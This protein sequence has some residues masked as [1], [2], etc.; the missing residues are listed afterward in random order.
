[1]PLTAMRDQSLSCF[2]DREPAEVGRAREETRKA[3]FGWGLGG[4]R[5]LAEI[6]ISEWSPMPS[7]M[8]KG[9]SRRASPMPVVTCT[10]RSTMTARAVPS[11]AR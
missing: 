11:A 2:L 10:C 9:L 3:L 8:A 4:S 5:D 1:M 6:I 7:A